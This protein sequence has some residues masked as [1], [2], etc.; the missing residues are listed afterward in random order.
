[1]FWSTEV[2]DELAESLHH[3]SKCRAWSFKTSE[4]IRDR[5]V[6]DSLTICLADCKY[7]YDGPTNKLSMCCNLCMMP[8]QSRFQY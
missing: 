1:V 6:A 7:A 8:N 2:F 3:S 4:Q 5:N